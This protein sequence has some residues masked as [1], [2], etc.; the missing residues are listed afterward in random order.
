MGI[1]KK[2][3]AQG[4]GWVNSRIRPSSFEA[5][6]CGQPFGDLRITGHFVKVSSIPQRQ[7][8]IRS[9]P[10]RIIASRAVAASRAGATKTVM[11][12]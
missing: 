4:N 5:Q 12:L 11:K 9:M 2:L 6:P 8:H 7:P 3:A 1:G 10:E